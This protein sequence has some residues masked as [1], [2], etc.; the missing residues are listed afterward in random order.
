MYLLLAFA[1][2]WIPLHIHLMI[3]F[4]TI[5]N[6][7]LSDKLSSFALVFLNT[8]CNANADSVRKQA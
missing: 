3:H 1:C 4:G 2:Q 7:S 6:I 5:N 8:A